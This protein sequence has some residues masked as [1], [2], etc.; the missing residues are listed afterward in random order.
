M[1]GIVR[2]LLDL[3]QPYLLVLR[4]KEQHKQRSIVVV[5]VGR[6]VGGFF[7]ADAM[8]AVSVARQSQNACCRMAE[9]RHDRGREA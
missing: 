5:V 2:Q 4:Y 6:G 8:L 3:D 7:A 1:S 9:G